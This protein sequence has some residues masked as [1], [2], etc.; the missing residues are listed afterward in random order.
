ME[1]LLVRAGDVL[2]LDH[3]GKFHPV[4]PDGRVAINTLVE[5][6]KTGRVKFVFN[7]NTSLSTFLGNKL[8]TITPF[9]FLL[10]GEELFL[11]NRSW[12]EPGAQLQLL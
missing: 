1:K 2:E 3:D 12:L 10:E 5:L 6:P 7:V 9:G 11:F 4:F 8:A